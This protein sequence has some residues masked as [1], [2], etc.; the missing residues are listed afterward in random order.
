MTTV[1]LLFESAAALRQLFQHR[2]ETEFAISSQGFDILVRLARSP[3][4][5]LRMSELADQTLLTPSGLTRAVDRLA[6]QGLVS[7]RACPEDRRGA[8][9]VLSAE[10]KGLMDRAVPLHASHIDDVLSAVFSPAD[11]RRLSDL[12]R[13]L[14]DHLYRRDGSR[15]LM[16]DEC[17]LSPSC[18]DA[19]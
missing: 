16:E 1:G 4:N 13:R 18:P 17:G 3:G 5:E 11:E 2:L 19:S 8:F 14:R 10:G 6:H 9:A 15:E 7:R 12:L